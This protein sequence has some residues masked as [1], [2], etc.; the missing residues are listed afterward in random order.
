MKIDL[1]VPGKFG[2]QRIFQHVYNEMSRKV[3]YKLE[4]MTEVVIHQR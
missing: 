3:I 2:K 1:T 4:E